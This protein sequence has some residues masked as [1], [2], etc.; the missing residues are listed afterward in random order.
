MNIKGK[1]KAE[2]Q[3]LLGCLKG[4]D[5]DRVKAYD[6]LL[7]EAAFLAVTLEQLRDTI[8]NEGPTERYQNGANQY[9]QKISA[10]VTTYDRLLNTYS[11]VMT[12]ISKGLPDANEGPF[13]NMW[14]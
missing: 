14:K 8:S 5:E 7:N 2:Y 13:S 9:G 1:Q 3:R 11:K 10:T 6:S 12:Q 4:L